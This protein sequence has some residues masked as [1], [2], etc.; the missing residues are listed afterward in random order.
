MQRKQQIGITMLFERRHDLRDI[1]GKY[2]DSD[3]R[4]RANV[5]RLLKLAL[6][7]AQ[8]PIREIHFK[9]SIGVSCV[10]ASSAEMEDVRDDFLEWEATSGP[11][12]RL[13][14]EGRKHATCHG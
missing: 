10:T 13:R 6:A 2:T 4:G 9:G 11:R 1:F 3:I 8:H 14:Q 5:L 12:V 7:S